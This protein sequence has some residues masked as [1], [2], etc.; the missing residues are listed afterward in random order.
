MEENRCRASIKSQ[1]L[2]H[3]C[4]SGCGRLPAAVGE[5][6]QTIPN[7]HERRHITTGSMWRFFG[8]YSSQKRLESVNKFGQRRSVRAK[9]NQSECARHRKWSEGRPPPENA[10][11]RTHPSRSGAISPLDSS[12]KKYGRKVAI[13]SHEHAKTTA[14]RCLK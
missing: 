5:I 10:G 13:N 4:I 1:L 3:K 7:N 11:G 9:W 14:E 8:S 6:M 12:L 2:W